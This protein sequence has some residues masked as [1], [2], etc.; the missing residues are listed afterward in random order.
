MNRR[1]Y[2][3][4]HAI[5]RARRGEG[6][7]PTPRNLTALFVDTVTDHMGAASV[8][9]GDGDV[10]AALEDYYRQALALE[11]AEILDFDTEI[12]ASVDGDAAWKVTWDDQEQRPRIASVPPESLWFETRPDNPREVTRIAQQYKLSADA[13]PVLF[14]DSLALG[15]SREAWVTEEWSNDRWRVWLNDDVKLD[16]P[17]PYGW[18]P[19]CHIPNWKNPGETFGRG[20]PERIRDLQ[21]R[22]NYAEADLDDTMALAAAVV[23]FFGLDEQMQ[24]A[25]RPGAAWTFTDESTRVEIID[26]LKGNHG[27][28]VLEY[29]KQIRQ[30]AHDIARVP[31]SAL[32]NTSRNLSGFALQTELGPLIRLVARK[33]L[34][35]TAAHR[36]RAMLIASLGAQFGGQPEMS[37]AMIP[38]VSW[39]EAVPA[40][41]ADELANAE[42][43]VRIGRDLAQVLR[44]IGVEDPIA[45]LEARKQQNN[46]GLPGGT[47]ERGTQQRERPADDDPFA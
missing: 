17:N 26:F 11:D 18:M 23:A 38:S 35:R 41:R 29:V 36:R 21:D 7:P 8:S 32:G 39:S 24:P 30:E 16:V 43:E 6:M 15:T 9:F 14:A 12:A 34:T 3:G 42:A 33:R 45:E 47:I 13:F 46:E 2:A 37:P 40:D 10:A 25:I 28:Q 19:Y 1:Y 22:L 44:S 5:R 31:V 4:E 27:T 20:D